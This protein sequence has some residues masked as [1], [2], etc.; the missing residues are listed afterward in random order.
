MCGWNYL[1]MPQTPFFL[2]STNSIVNLGYEKWAPERK[3][4]A[5]GWTKNFDMYLD[6]KVH[7]ANM[8]PIWGRQDPGG[9]HDCPMNFAI[10]VQLICA[11]LGNPH[12]ACTGTSPWRHRDWDK[13][14]II[15]DAND[16]K[17]ILMYEN[18]CSLMQISMKSFPNGLRV[19]RYVSIGLV[20]G[21]M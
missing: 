16:F 11:M 5:T 10:W 14:A 4:S 9:P 21:L 13:M 8:G 3:H 20:N 7:G 12:H 1:S 2:H 18:H 17:A 19:N 15:W 6:S